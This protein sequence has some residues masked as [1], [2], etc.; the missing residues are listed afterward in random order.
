MQQSTS[1]LKNW[2]PRKP[3]TLLLTRTTILSR[4]R[5][6]TKRIKTIPDGKE[7]SNPELDGLKNQKAVESMKKESHGV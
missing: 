3:R 2:C 4:K 1:K 6:K 5:V 7:S